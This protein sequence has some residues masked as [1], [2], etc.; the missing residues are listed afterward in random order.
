MDAKITKK[1]LNILLSYDWIKIIATAVAAI[2]L[3]SLLFTMTATRVTQA[4]NFTVFNYTGSHGGSDFTYLAD[5]LKSK[6]AFSYDILEIVST[7][8]TTNDQYSSTVLQT[9]ISTGEGDALFAANIPDTN[10]VKATDDEGNPTEYYTYLEEF[11]YSYFNC[12]DSFD[13]YLENMEEYLNDCYGGDYKNGVLDANLVESRF[14]T[15]I[16][17]LK[18]KRFKKESQIVKGIEQEKGRIETYRKNLLNFQ[19]Y[20]DKGY[21]KFQETI[22]ELQD[23]N[24]N[25]IEKKITT[26]NL[27]PENDDRMSALKSAVYYSKTIQTEDG[28]LRTSTAEN[29]NLVLLDL[30][31]SKYKYTR[32]EGLSFVNYLIET[33]CSE[34]KS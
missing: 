12:V 3:W 17:Q 21:I 4:Q 24:G 25:K 6:K 34:L 28:E 29:M 22:L 18:D 15:R 11:L 27:C 14:R 23:N 32:W 7:D 9:R 16:K 26:L 8:I 1:R 31:E 19:T 30:A 10:R 13:V 33:Y 20:L 2:I 5:S